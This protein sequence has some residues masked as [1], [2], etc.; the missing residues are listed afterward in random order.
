MRVFIG[1][2]LKPD[3]S[4][5]LADRAKVLYLPNCRIRPIPARNLHC[6]IKF[7]GDIEESQL[8]N[9]RNVVQSSAAEVSQFEST[10]SLFAC[11]PKSGPTKVVCCGLDGDVDQLRHLYYAVEDRLQIFG[12]E[13]EDRE[14]LP[15]ITVARVKEDKSKGGLRKFV[16]GLP[17]VNRK[18]PF[19]HLTL[20]ESKL[21]S[22]GA[23]YQVLFRAKLAVRPA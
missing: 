16:G 7:I 23:E 20:F 8:E 15:H 4:E 1:L 5:L 21:S 12:L 13:P 6:T 19:N 22:A 18:A 17:V 2:E 10:I 11:L 14:F 9:L 3:L